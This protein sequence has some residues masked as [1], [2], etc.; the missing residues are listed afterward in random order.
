MNLVNILS[1]IEKYLHNRKNKLFLVPVLAHKGVGIVEHSCG[2]L[3]EISQ[4]P[5]ENI[6][7]YYLYKFSEREIDII[8]LVWAWCWR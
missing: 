8:S 6:Y 5:P 3:H 2:I 7:L 1:L 4:N